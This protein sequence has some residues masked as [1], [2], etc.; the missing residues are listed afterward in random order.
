M[1][2]SPLASGWASQARS[3]DSTVGG[4]ATSSSVSQTGSTH[5]GLMPARTRPE[6]TLLWMFRATSSS[7]P[8]AATDNIAVLTDKELPAVAKNAVSAL[9]ASA[10]S[11]SA[12]LVTGRRVDDVAPAAEL[13][14]GV[15]DGGLRVVHGAAVPA[16]GEYPACRR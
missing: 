4:W 1:C 9:T 3:T 15:E 12:L 2:S 11:S 6:I 14:H 16:A 13:Q 7:S 8:W 10:I 5:T